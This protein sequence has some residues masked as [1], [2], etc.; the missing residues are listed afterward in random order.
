MIWAVALVLL[1]TLMVMVADGTVQLPITVAVFVS[2]SSGSDDALSHCTSSAAPCRTLTGAVQAASSM[3]EQTHGYEQLQNAAVTVTVNA[4]LYLDDC[5]SPLGL[6]VPFGAFSLVVNPT[7][8]ASVATFDCQGGNGGGGGGG[9]GEGSSFLVMNVTAHV[10]M[11]GIV[12]KNAF[13]QESGAAVSWQCGN[14]TSNFTSS[15]SSSTSSSTTAT[16]TTTTT[17]SSS[18]TTSTTT[19]A[20]ST[21]TTTSSSSSSSSSSTTTTT[22][23]TTT[24]TTSSSTANASISCVFVMESCSFIN[25]SAAGLDGGGALSLSLSDG[26]GNLTLVDVRVINSDFWSNNASTLATETA[27]GGGGAI[28]IVLNSLSNSTQTI[29]AIEGGTFWN[30]TAADDGGAINIASTSNHFRCSFTV[31]P[32]VC[33]NNYGTFGGAV[34]FYMAGPLINTNVTVTGFYANNR[35]LHGGGAVLFIYSGMNFSNNILDGS[36]VNNF[37]EIGGA[38]YLVQSGPVTDQS[39]LVTTGYFYNNTAQSDGGAAT[40]TFFKSV[41]DSELVVSGNYSSNVAQTQEAGA[42]SLELTGVSYSGSRFL[43]TNGSFSNNNA[44]FGGALSVQVGCIVPSGAQVNL[45]CVAVADVNIQVSNSMFSENTALV[46][47]G[48]VFVVL[49]GNVTA[50]ED[51]AAT[52][53][54]MVNVSSCQFYSNRAQASGGAISLSMTS[55]NDNAI[56]IGGCVFGGNSAQFSGGALSI[57]GVVTSSQIQQISSWNASTVTIHRHCVFTGNA[58][59]FG[60]AIDFVLNNVNMMENSG[61]S[62]Q[63]TAFFNNS[64]S[65]QGGAVKLTATQGNCFLELLHCTIANSYAGIEGGGLFVQGVARVTVANSTF[66][67]CSADVAAS[68]LGMTGTGELGSFHFINSSQIISPLG[69]AESSFQGQ[70]SFVQGVQNITLGS[71]VLQCVGGT[72]QSSEISTLQIS[73]YSISSNNVV[74]FH[75]NGT[76]TTLQVW[77]SNCAPCAA[78]SYAL[79]RPECYGTTVAAKWSKQAVVC[80]DCPSGAVCAGGSDVSSTEG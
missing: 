78:R 46:A 36:F 22:T 14:F 7:S 80:F 6:W 67:N 53:R 69:V 45:S 72:V 73:Q 21:T 34:M 37:A 57:L 11:R 59:A 10:V 42:V 63:Q 16:T 51:Q 2:S 18:S 12:V 41:Q 74:G 50:A 77:T 17:S 27:I 60:G 52:S 61:L 66:V 30:N 25:N 39:S 79:N 65:Q 71:H 28:S 43:F 54:V 35:A 19:T 40:F 32:L 3:V 68:A 55:M 31:A 29:I 62:V 38:T 23:T 47:G 49:I 24:S 58:A 26:D 75:S 33:S 15:F 48:A 56:A 70:Q 76:S 5:S 20:T 4:G 13:S 9:G 8:H 64:A 44:E 1:S